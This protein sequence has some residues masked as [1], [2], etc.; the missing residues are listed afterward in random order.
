MDPKCSVCGIHVCESGNDDTLPT[1]CPMVDDEVYKEAL[2]VVRSEKYNKF[3]KTSTLIERDGYAI[4]PRVKETMVLIDRMKFKK[5]GLAFC[6]GFIKEAKILT[7]IFKD[8][9][10]EL[11]SAMCKTGGV[12]KTYAGLLEEN[13]ISPGEY[14][15]MCNPVA[16]AKLLNKAG[17]EFNIVM[18]LCVGH[19]SLFYK[20]SDALCTTIV[21]KDR[22]TGNNPCVALYGADGYFAGRLDLDK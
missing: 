6:G 9:G 5:V 16:Q 2:E 12:D 15:P 17:T 8:N 1:F 3:Y 11:T 20:F 21:V 13:K 7:K 4:W 10:I 14:E 18:G 19:D 22:V